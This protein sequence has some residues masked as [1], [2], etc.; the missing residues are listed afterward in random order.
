MADVVR[1]RI[2]S[3]EY[4]PHFLISEVQLAREFDVNRDTIRKTTQA[5]RDAGLIS[6]TPGMGSFVEERPKPAGEGES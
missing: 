1:A 6:T 5:L 4:P 2:S 3:G